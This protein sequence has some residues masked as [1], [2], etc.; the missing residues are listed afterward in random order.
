MATRRQIQIIERAARRHRIRPDTLWGIWG[1]ET[2][3]GRNKNNSSAGA[4]GDFQFMPATA[5]AYGIDPHNFG[6]AANAAAKYIATYKGR[7]RRGAVAAYNAGPAGN[8]NNP[9]TRAYVPKVLQL[10]RT[11][12]GGK[13]GGGGRG[14]SSGGSGAGSTSVSFPAPQPGGTQISD[15]LRAQQGEQ[16]RPLPPLGEIPAPAHTA[17]NLVPMPKGPVL[18]PVATAEPQSQVGGL[19]ESLRQIEGL[20]G[21]KLQQLDVRT[22]PGSGSGGG[23]PNGKLVSP[24]A[25]N[26]SLGRIV[27]IAQRVEKEQPAYL[28]GGGHG[29]TP[30]GFGAD[31]DCSGFVSQLLQV[32]PRTSG[33]F[34]SYGAKGKG[35]HVTIYAHQGH[36]L[37]EINGQFYGTSAS[38][39]GGGAGKIPRPS[40][41]YLKRF[42]RRHPRGL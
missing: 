12:P 25:P 34:M 14:R 23:T 15:L 17:Q 3:F 27:R 13:N 36:V 6:Q 20:R 8:P 9:E 32:R 39:R 41:A 40:A 42:V 24:D 7:G 16:T 21:P 1:A 19:A 28:W 4:Q 30:A 11:W 29:A 2:N 35:K 22:T 26:A 37:A 18:G 33:Q 38:N 31:V 5:R 10:A